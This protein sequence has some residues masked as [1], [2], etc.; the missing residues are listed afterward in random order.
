VCDQCKR[1]FAIPNGKCH[2]LEWAPTVLSVFTL[3][4]LDFDAGDV[5]IVDFD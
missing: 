1:G 4:L 2:S 3:G 5:D